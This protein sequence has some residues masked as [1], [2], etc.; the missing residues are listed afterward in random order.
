MINTKQPAFDHDAASDEHASKR[1]VPGLAMEST[2]RAEY[3]IKRMVSNISNHQSL[4][5]LAFGCGVERFLAWLPLG[6]Q[7]YVEMA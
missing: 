2:Y 6:A 1:S 7:C 5:I 4:K 3:K